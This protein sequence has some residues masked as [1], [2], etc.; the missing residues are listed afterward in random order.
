MHAPQF[1]K[2]SKNNTTPETVVK[3]AV[4]GSH[5]LVPVHKRVDEFLK[6]AKMESDFQKLNALACEKGIGHVSI[7]QCVLVRARRNKKNERA[8]VHRVGKT[9]RERARRTEGSAVRNPTNVGN[10]N[11]KGPSVSVSKGG[12]DKKKKK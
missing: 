1:G 7:V 12:Q 2:S 4:S 10:P 6:V 11:D 5:A 8:S 3:S 9:A